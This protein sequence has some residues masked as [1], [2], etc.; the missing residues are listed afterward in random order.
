MTKQTKLTKAARGRDCQIDE[1]SEVWRPVRGFEG[2][3]EISNS[4]R[5]HSLSRRVS[6]GAGERIVDGRLLRQSVKSGYPSV[7]LCSGSL[8]VDKHIHRLVAEAFV[9]GVGP[10]VRHLDGDPKNCAP[11]NLAWGTYAENEADKKI[12][13]TVIQG[14]RHHN[15][16]LTDE[17]VRAIRKMSRDG[18]SQL[19]IAAATGI[20][21]GSIGYVV[22]GQTWRHVQ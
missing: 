1:Y 8:Q 20:G 12:H 21:R 10:V 19:A 16:K 22:R 4:G 14:E 5:V 7:C 18:Y 11:A 13:G 9:A 2:L 6:I 3:Y 15:A 17:L